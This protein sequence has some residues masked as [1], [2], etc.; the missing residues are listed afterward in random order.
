MPEANSPRR[1]ARFEQALECFR[2]ARD[3]TDPETSPGVYGVIL[4]DIADTYRDAQDFKEAAEHFRQAVSYKERA[5][6][7]GDLATTMTALANTLASMGEAAEA[8]EVLE[9]LAG[10]VPKIADTGRRAAVLHNM[11]LSHEELGRLGLEGAYADAVAAYQAV[12]ALIDGESDPGWYATV[13][14]DIGDAYA[15]QE[16]LPQAHASYTE[17]VRYT[18]RIGETPASLIT[19]LIALGRTSR[20][21]G[22]L[23]GEAEGGAAV[24]GSVREP[25]ASQADAGVPGAAPPSDASPADTEPLDAPP[26]DTPPSRDEP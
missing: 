21:L 6:N 16:M 4:H 26:L 8:R 10:Q 23:E 9:R 7:P 11:G 24:N 22:R 18:R 20:R 5:D 12:L 2:E 15:S 25:G 13:L 19:V 17:A 14:K 1:P 3:L